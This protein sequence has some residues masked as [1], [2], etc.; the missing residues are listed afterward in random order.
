[1]DIVIQNRLSDETEQILY[2]IRVTAADINIDWLATGE[3]FNDFEHTPELRL[4]FWEYQKDTQNYALNTNFEL[5]HTSGFRTIK[6]S[7]SHSTD[8]LLCAT[9]GLDNIL[10][11]WALEDSD[12]IYKQGKTWACVK[13]IAYKN[14]AIESVSFSSDGSL[15]AA[16]FANNLCIFK[17]KSL[18]LKCV[19]TPPASFSGLFQECFVSLQ[20]K[21]SKTAN[22]RNI[23]TTFSNSIET[24]DNKF[25]Q[26]LS[27][28]K[29]SLKIINETHLNIKGKQDLYKQILQCSD[30]GFY[31]K[32]VTFKNLCIPCKI[33]DKKLSSTLAQRFKTNQINLAS[34][35]KLLSKRN[36]FK[37]KYKI[38]KL[39][40]GL[41][42]CDE[43]ATFLKFLNISKKKSETNGFENGT[44]KTE[45]KSK[46]NETSK[47]QKVVK[48]KHI[49]F[50]SAEYAHLV[51][52]CTEHRVFIWNLL[53]FRL[54][55]IL[56]L[57][58]EHLAFDP[59]TNL[60]ACFTKYNECK[61]CN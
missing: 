42:K 15:L 49:C 47:L 55:N 11:I 13:K 57:S 59:I 52:V 26:T 37:G 18:Q 58:V 56:K 24:G 9:V 38:K 45:E 43:V 54:T 61:E 22:K 33:S 19:L 5:P 36:Q 34:K 35:L 8:D 51:V 14:Q 20:N 32:I 31:Q 25:V 60:I 46:T 3:E 28:D 30:L 50:C 10:K 40:P 41:P 23:Y 17:T 2:D 6:F 39:F 48:I 12:N 4:K 16:G 44:S 1:M 27:A 53:N 7:N 29:S 21:S